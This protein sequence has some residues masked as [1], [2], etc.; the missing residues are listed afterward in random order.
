MLILSFPESRSQAQQ[1]AA[2]LGLV[3]KN[4]DIH[5]FPDGESRLV[6]PGDLPEQV[7][8]HRSLD[9]PNDKLVELLLA[10]D[11]AREQGV[12]QLTL[13]APYLCYM[14][15]DKAFHPGEVVSQ[16]IIGRFLASHF[17]QV[18]TVDAHLHRIQRLEQAI[19]ARHAQ[20]LSATKAMGQFL[21]QQDLQALLLGPDQ[22]SRQWVAAIADIARLDYVVAD[23]TRLGDQDVRISLPEAEYKNRDIVIVDDVISS[24]YTVAVAA[25]K[26]QEKGARA[27]HCLVTHALFAKQAVE[28]LRAA[29]IQQIWSSDS[30]SHSSNV[31]P[32]APLLAEALKN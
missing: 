27:V 16:K 13:V 24:G 10:A 22:E 19:P 21:K 32:L 14:R 5:H 7:I 8:F 1:L 15:Q 20:N 23:K 12:K 11:S 6:L 18:L 28:N 31:I 26:A 25:Q 30:I 3:C 29:G 4:V 2:A 17:D 9:R